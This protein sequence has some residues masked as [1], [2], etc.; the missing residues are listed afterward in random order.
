MPTPCTSATI[1]SL[2]E[3]PHARLILQ[4]WLHRQMIMDGILYLSDGLKSSGNEATSSLP[5]QVAANRQ[6]F[7]Q[8][9]EQQKKKE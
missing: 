9:L 5:C 1:Y 2:A 6:T 7:L 8:R 3:Y 4:Q